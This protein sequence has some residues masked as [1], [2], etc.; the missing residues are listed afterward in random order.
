MY[1]IWQWF[2]KYYGEKQYSAVYTAYC[3]HEVSEESWMMKNDAKDE[4]VLTNII[5]AG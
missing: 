5:I 3:I 2:L 1:E 4:D